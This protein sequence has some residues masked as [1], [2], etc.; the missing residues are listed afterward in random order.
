MTFLDS[1][2]SCFVTRLA[3]DHNRFG[4]PFEHNIGLCI[5]SVQGPL[6]TSVL[7]HQLIFFLV[8]A[9]SSLPPTLSPPSP[10][11][12]PPPLSMHC[13]RC[14]CPLAPSSMPLLLSC[15]C[16]LCPCW[17]CHACPC[18]S[19]HFPVVRAPAGLVVCV[20][21]G[22]VVCAPTAPIICAPAALVVPLLS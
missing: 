15:P 22:C 6:A 3:M 10:T 20:P 4:T 12:L 14:P 13:P 16:C 17:P 19:C 18:C 21:A 7:H 9:L 11:P 5:N 2:R 1:P 8:L